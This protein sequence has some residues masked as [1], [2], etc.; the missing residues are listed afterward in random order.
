MY[1][2]Q[3]QQAMQQQ[4]SSFESDP[5]G[6]GTS[7]TPHPLGGHMPMHSNGVLLS[8][9]RQPLQASSPHR[10]PQQVQQ[11]QPLPTAASAPSQGSITPTPIQVDHTYSPVHPAPSAPAPAAPAP[12]APT[13][14]PARFARILHAFAAEHKSELSVEGH[15]CIKVRGGKGKEI[16]EEGTA[17]ILLVRKN[18][19]G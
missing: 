8:P 15:E 2:Q 16:S 13:A 19:H 12:A 9:S 6:Y 17:I 3:Q 11:Q 1:Q 7:V 18:H 4:P 14:P 5:G 10:Q